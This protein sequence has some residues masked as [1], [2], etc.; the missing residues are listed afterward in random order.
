MPL[1][2]SEF[3]KSERGRFPERDR[4]EDLLAPLFA[5]YARVGVLKN[6]EA[7]TGGVVPVVI[8]NWLSGMA[9]PSVGIQTAVLS[10]LADFKPGNLRE[11]QPVIVDERP[12]VEQKSD[13][14]ARVKNKRG[15]LLSRQKNIARNE[16]F[17]KELQKRMR[18]QGKII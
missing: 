1:K 6:I 10:Y 18:E 17:I 16:E 14:P 12:S 2:S 7:N 5:R 11:M 13:K 3:G 9:E 8:E 15:M 4:L